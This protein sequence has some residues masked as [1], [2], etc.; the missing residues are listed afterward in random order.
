[1][2][3]GSGSYSGNYRIFKIVYLENARDIK[4]TTL[5]Q[6]YNR[7][8]TWLQMKVTNEMH[9]ELEENFVNR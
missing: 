2:A 9:V 5:V 4:Y 8:C 3:S 1:M 7:N 6:C